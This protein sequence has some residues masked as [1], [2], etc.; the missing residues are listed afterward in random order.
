[1][2]KLKQSEYTQVLW[3]EMATVVE[4]IKSN[5]RTHIKNMCGFLKRI[6]TGVYI[7][8]ALLTTALFTLALA[9]PEIL[10]NI[11]GF[12][13]LTKDNVTLLKIPVMALFITGVFCDTIKHIQTNLI[14]FNY[15]R[16]LKKGKSRT[17]R[18][19]KKDN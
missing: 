3:D 17:E 12:G 4:D 10:K 7:Q 9:V 2:V 16:L 6:F 1:M 15:N 11:F 13:H 8:S 5:G 19:Q 14:S 18:K